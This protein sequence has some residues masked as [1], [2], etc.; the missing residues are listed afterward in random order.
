MGRG[1]SESTDDLIKA[2]CVIFCCMVIC[3]AFLL[4]FSFRKLDANEVGL[5]YS[6]NS[7][8]IDY[9]QLYDSGV[10]F[11]GVGHSFIK[12]PRSVNEIKLDGSE[13]NARTADGLFVQ[14][15]VKLLYRL[16]IEKDALANLY[17][18]FGENGYVD[19]YTKLT[20]AVI[21]DVASQYTAFQFWLSRDNITTAMLFGLSG[22]LGDVYGLVD[23]FLLTNFELPV[24]FQDAL[25]ETDV[26]KQERDKVQ[27]EQETVQAQTDTRVLQAAKQADI[28]GLEANATAT[29]FSLGI[30]AEVVKIQQ[31]VTAELNSYES[32]VTQLGF[33]QQQLVTFVWLDTLSKST[34]S[35]KYF[36]VPKPPSFL[37]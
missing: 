12:F 7:L 19:A 23:N 35:T 16:Q 37:F 34:N 9:S 27:F 28:I 11:L 30:D 5:D 29:S 25:T 14:L 3:S 36:T 4:G 32:L 31:L 6:A 26:R 1:A 8:T 17:L 15:S 24:K 18:M 13:Y 22:A 2:G 10:Y 21:R 20:R 33:T